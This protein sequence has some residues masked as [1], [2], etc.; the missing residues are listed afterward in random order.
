MHPEAGQE[1]RALA[2]EKLSGTLPIFED[3]P[4]LELATELEQPVMSYACPKDLVEPVVGVTVSCDFRTRYT[5][6]SGM[7]TEICGS[8]VPIWA[9]TAS[10][11]RPLSPDSRAS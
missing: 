11:G 6:G 3:A 5:P 1:L 2:E 7:W 8:S 9:M 10:P 4:T